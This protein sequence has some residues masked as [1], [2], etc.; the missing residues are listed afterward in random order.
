[1]PLFSAR[2]ET[3]PS[4]GDLGLRRRPDMGHAFGDLYDAEAAIVA[5]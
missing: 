1:M 2:L 4:G 5:G 3:G